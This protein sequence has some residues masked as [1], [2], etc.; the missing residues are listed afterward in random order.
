MAQEKLERMLFEAFLHAATRMGP[1][2]K[3][4]SCFLNNW[5]E[6]N[7][8]SAARRDVKDAA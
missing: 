4:M 3:G 8:V 7:S 5:R 1:R 6:T 2:V